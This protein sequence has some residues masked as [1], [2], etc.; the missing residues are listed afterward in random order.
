MTEQDEDKP[1]G[2]AGAEISPARGLAI[3]ALGYV[4][5]LVA[6]ALEDLRTIAESVRVL[7]D[8]AR[9]LVSIERETA[10]MSA[11]VKLMRQGVDRLGDKVDGLDSDMVK[12]ARGVEPLDAKL[13]DMRRALH[14][15]SRAGALFAR[16]RETAEVEAPVEARAE[17]TDG[18]S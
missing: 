15:L 6:G 3:D 4:P 8:V 14:P 2:P 17:R 16:R 18:T 7:P 1:E 12:V 11:E 13:D 9:T 10:A 5:R